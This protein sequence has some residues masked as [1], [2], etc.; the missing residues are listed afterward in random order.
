M[1]ESPE[2]TSADHP[3]NTTRFKGFNELK[4][5]AFA[6]KLEWIEPRAASIE[7][8]SAVHSAGLIRFLKSAASQLHP[9]KTRIIE[10]SPTYITC[11]SWQAALTA[12]GSTLAVTREVLRTQMHPGFALVRPPGHHASQERSQGFC[13]LNNLAIALAAS[14]FENTN[15]NPERAAVVDFD[16]HHGNG[17]EAILWDRPQAG[18]FSFHQEGSYPG[19]GSLRE[20]PHARGRLL[21]LPLPAFSG[22]QALEQIARKVIRPWLV[23]LRPDIVFVSAGFDGHWMDPLTNLGFT[24]TGFYFLAR[25]LADVAAELCHGRI[26]FVLEG[27]YNP[28]VL[29]AN[30]R[31]VLSA[32]TGESSFIDTS[33]PSPYREPD[34]LER[35]DQFLN[36]HKIQ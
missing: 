3:E 17:T 35:L 22:D 14:H 33:G 23:A 9:G 31:A 21:N 24:T 18:F 6:A 32:I 7:E 12:A 19:S 11:G 26:V 34:I 20:A 29:T 36:L 30:I 10:P 5:D 28:T 4:S 2:H 1:V 27:G 13:L 15:K 16:A 25:F 8:V